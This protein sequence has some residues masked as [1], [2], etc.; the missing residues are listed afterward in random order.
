MYVGH[1]AVALV[2]KSW[3]P[4]LSIVP[5]T[6]ACFGPDWLELALMIPKARE[7]MAIY[8][9]SIPAV[10]IGATLAALLHAALRRPGSRWIAV[11]W[12]LHWPADYVTGLKPVTSLERM[13]G[14]D[15]YHLPLVDFAI[16]TAAVV[17]ASRYFARRLAVSPARRRVV[18]VLAAALIL[19]QGAIDLALAVLRSPA[20]SPS[21]ANARWQ[22]HLVASRSAG[23]PHSAWLLHFDARTHTASVRW[24]RTVPGV[25]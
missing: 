14:L 24:R 13:V 8:T 6:L 22:P 15:L 20:W 9:H 23:E 18:T 21:L 17:F 1:A 12:L 4:R 16:E 5:L 7:G 25:S 3:E 2:L 10:L 19:L 11:G